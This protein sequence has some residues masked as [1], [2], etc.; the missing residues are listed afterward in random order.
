MNP[1][2][3]TLLTESG[4]ELRGSGENTVLYYNNLPMPH[5]FSKSE[6]YLEGYILGFLN[7]KDMCTQ[8]K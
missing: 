1:Y 6:D 5:T 2:L 7:H 8:K 3:K 4:I